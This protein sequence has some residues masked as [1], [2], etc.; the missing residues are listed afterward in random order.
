MVSINKEKKKRTC[1]LKSTYYNFDQLHL[2]TKHTDA[3]TKLAHLHLR[4]FVG[5]FLRLVSLFGSSMFSHKLL[6]A[7]EEIEE[8]EER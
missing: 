3:N 1:S 7:E 6:F 2:P 8:T 5:Q 4:R